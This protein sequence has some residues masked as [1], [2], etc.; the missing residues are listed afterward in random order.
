[1]HALT[2]LLFE[3]PLALSAVLALVLFVL[4]IYWRRG[5]RGRYLLIGTGFAVVLL[6]LQ[7]VVETRREHAG[8]LLKR[9]ERDL[10]ASRSEAL[11]E[12]LATDFDAGEG[13]DRPAFLDLV[14]H[15][16]AQ[17]RI[18]WLDRLGLNVQ[19][20]T[21]E[22]FTV[23]VSYRADVSWHQFVGSVPSEWSITF[24]RR[25]DPWQIT[26]IRPLSIAG[27]RVA[28]WHFV[29]NRGRPRPGRV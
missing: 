11:S 12:A 28:G 5:G 26:T 13:L 19:Q 8:R 29:V 23:L 21:G 3:S 9:I 16:L 2:W 25:G 6:V 10:V 20:S 18:R 27:D 14:D 4:L 24:G 17:I 1:M 7:S 22:S 15:Q